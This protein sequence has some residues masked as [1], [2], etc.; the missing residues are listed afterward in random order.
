M[1][2]PVHHDPDGRQA[3]WDRHR[4]QDGRYIITQSP[5]EG[6]MVLVTLVQDE[7][8]PGKDYF[9]MKA[10][11]KHYHDQEWAISQQPGIENSFTLSLRGNLEPEFNSDAL[12]LTDDGSLALRQES[13]CHPIW[14]I[15]YEK[16]FEEKDSEGN[17]H[18]VYESCI[19]REVGTKRYWSVGEDAKIVLA[20]GT[21]KEPLGHQHFVLTRIGASFSKKQQRYVHAIT[22][23]DS[24]SVTAPSDNEVKMLYFA[25]NKISAGDPILRAYAI[26][27][28]TDAC[29]VNPLKPND[30]TEKAL[31]PWF[32]LAI[33]SEL[34]KEGDKVA[35]QNIKSRKGKPL[36][37]RLH[38]IPWS[39][40][41][42]HHAMSGKVLRESFAELIDKGDYIGVLACARDNAV[43]D[44]RRGRLVFHV[45]AS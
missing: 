34:P 29:A 11:D 22:S 37:W 20:E 28:A 43:C 44:V 16:Y 2:H 32:E 38:T 23:F 8:S 4:V 33:F 3:N 35:I 39:K 36:V 19:I 1:E 45:R 41:L 25:T 17:P 40:D 21:G 10:E 18:T 26:R 7:F 24:L 13:S 31:S 15:D 6:K 14:S 5:S 30:E 12:Y 42:K 9:W 27:L